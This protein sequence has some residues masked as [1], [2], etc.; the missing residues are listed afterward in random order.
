MKDDKM[1]DPSNVGGHASL[2]TYLK[3]IETG[4]SGFRRM[5]NEDWEAW[6][7]ARDEIEP[8]IPTKRSRKRVLSSTEQQPKAKKARKEPSKANSKSKEKAKSK[9]KTKSKRKGMANDAETASEAATEASDS[10]VPAVDIGPAGD[11]SNDPGALS[12]PPAP[13]TGAN[14]D[15][16]GA[17]PDSPPLDDHLRITI[18]RRPTTPP[19]PTTVTNSAPPSSPNFLLHPVP[20]QAQH[21]QNTPNPP[22]GSPSRGRR[23][24]HNSWDHPFINHTPDTISSGR[25]PSRSNSPSSRS[26]SPARRTRSNKTHT[27]AAASPLAALTTGIAFPS[28]TDGISSTS[29]PF[30]YSPTPPPLS[31]GPPSPWFGADN[32]EGQ[33]AFNQGEWDFSDPH[34]PVLGTPEL[35][36][37]IPTLSE[38]AAPDA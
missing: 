21:N 7:K 30:S 28:L 24:Y 25:P 32:P 29:S 14:I 19:T 38:F 31:F 6:N 22:Q 1:V 3:R 12:L 13:Q 33:H 34:P 18:N 4:K 16:F 9:E 8:V 26:G 27:P 35:R 23:G 10:E 17:V 11:H 5:T 37:T 20:M 36:G 15:F 2:C